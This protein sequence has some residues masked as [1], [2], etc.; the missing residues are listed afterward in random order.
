VGFRFRGGFFSR[1]LPLSFWFVDG[2]QG[3]TDGRTDGQMDEGGAEVGRRMEWLVCSSAG[4]GDLFDSRVAMNILPCRSL[5]G[6][7]VLG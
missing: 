5:T 7:G 4:P 1:C 2:Y 3:R 6:R